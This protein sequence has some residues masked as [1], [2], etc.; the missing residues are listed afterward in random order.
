MTVILPKRSHY[1]SNRSFLEVFVSREDKFKLVE[2][3][4]TR[5]CH[6]SKVVITEESDTILMRARAFNQ[7]VVVKLVLLMSHQQK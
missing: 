2:I 6:L 1:N 4:S 5:S 7:I 3:I